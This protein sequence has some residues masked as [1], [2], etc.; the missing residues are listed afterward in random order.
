VKGNVMKTTKHNP[1]ISSRRRKNERKQMAKT[2]DSIDTKWKR[3]ESKQK[4]PIQ[5]E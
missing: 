5:R 3:E 2:S 4:K 1:A